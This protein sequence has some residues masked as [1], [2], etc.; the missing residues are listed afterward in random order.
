MESVVEA[1]G[2]CC[3]FTDRLQNYLELPASDGLHAS[4]YRQAR[5]LSMTFLLVI[6]A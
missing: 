3:K 5:S 6:G 1:S 2:E 4:F